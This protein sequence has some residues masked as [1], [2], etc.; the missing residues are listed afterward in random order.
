MSS[1]TFKKKNVFTPIV[2][3]VKKNGCRM[4]CLN[5]TSS[6]KDHLN[7]IQNIQIT[8]IGWENPLRT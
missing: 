2:S 1:L 7:D 8:P 4:N 3:V 6:K 5:D